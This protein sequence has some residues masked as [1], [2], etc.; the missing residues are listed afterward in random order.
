MSCCRT[1]L[2]KYRSEQDADE[3]IST[4]RLNA[5]T[6]FPDAEILLCTRTSASTA[7]MT[8]LYSS[9]EK[10]DRAMAA[11]KPILEDAKANA[12]IESMETHEGDAFS[13]RRR[14]SG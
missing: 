14:K 12:K 8:S 7:V 1:T 2:L 10:A 3:L 6:D 11:R 5:S 9:K 4:Y 13:L